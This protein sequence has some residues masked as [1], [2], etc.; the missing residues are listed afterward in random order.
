MSNR[1]KQ[2]DDVH[3]MTS[4]EVWDRMG[5]QVRGSGP[6]DEAAEWRSL[7]HNS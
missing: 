4:S 1:D 6:L 7:S 3:S 2:V 5:D